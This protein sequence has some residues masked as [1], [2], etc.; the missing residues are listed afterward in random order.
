MKPPQ[1]VATL[2]MRARTTLHRRMHL[3]LRPLD[4][5]IPEPAPK[6]SFAFEEMTPGTERAYLDMLPSRRAL[7]QARLGSG[8]RCFLAMDGERIAHGYWMGVRRVRIDYMERDLVLPPDSVYT[9]DSYSPDAYRGRGAGAGDGPARHG[10]R[11]RRGAAARVVPARGGE[12][13]RHPAGGGHRL[14]ARRRL[15][16]PAGRAVAAALDGAAGRGGAAS[17]RA[18]ALGAPL[19]RAFR[20]GPVH[21]NAALAWTAETD[22]HRLEL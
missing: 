8:A 5:P 14:P 20:L 3:M 4:E 17:P 13:R 10:R 2:A 16:L 18:L 15:P 9:Y 22:P 1:P 21:D 19:D 6:G 12:R 7:V 11:A